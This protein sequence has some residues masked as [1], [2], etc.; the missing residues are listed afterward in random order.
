MSWIETLPSGR[1]APSTETLRARATRSYDHK[2][3]AKTFLVALLTDTARGE[4]R[5]PRGGAVP[6]R[7]WARQVVRRPR[8]PSDHAGSPTS[9]ATGRTC[10]R[11]ATPNSKT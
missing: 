4:W 2:A 8:R 5:D 1:Y 3:D 10:S 7:E 6:F 9:A 11:A